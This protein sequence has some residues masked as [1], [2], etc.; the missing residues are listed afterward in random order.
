MAAT[1]RRADFFV[2]DVY[3]Y[4]SVLAPGW[5]QKMKLQ[6]EWSR[7]ILLRDAGR[8]EN[9]LYMFDHSKLPESGEVYVFGRRFGRNFEAGCSVPIVPAAPTCR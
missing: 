8:D 1:G 5:V 4:L 6:L 9:L 3:I 7:P 2:S